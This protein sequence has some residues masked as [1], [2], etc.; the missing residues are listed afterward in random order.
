VELDYYAVTHPGQVRTANQD[1]VLTYVAPGAAFALFAVADGVGG[2][3]RGAEASHLAMSILR[4]RAEGCRGQAPIECVVQALHEANEAIILESAATPMASTI[5]TAIVSG[6]T[7]EIAHAGDSRAYLYRD[8]SLMQITEDHS[9]VEEQVQSGKMTP[10]EG[11]RSNRRNVITRCLGAAPELDLERRPVAPLL[12]G[13]TLMLCSDGL[14]AVV[15]LL[16]MAFLLRRS[17]TAREAAE[18]LLARANELGGPD[19]VAVVVVRALEPGTASV[20]DTAEPAIT[21][22]LRPS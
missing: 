6:E 22:E 13:D 3:P 17:Q 8:D 2:L 12:P 5:V 9:W 10:E 21:A 7:F 16:E 15:T 19:N 4:R 18:R 20:A 14:H 1:E 11:A